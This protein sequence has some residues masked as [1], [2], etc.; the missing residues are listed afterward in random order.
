MK[1]VLLVVALAIAASAQKTPVWPLRFQQEFVESYK[2]TTY[3]D[4]GKMWYDAERNMSKL[5]RTNG[6]YDAFCSSITNATTPC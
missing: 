1:L 2:T 5:A 4:V 6:K 3:H